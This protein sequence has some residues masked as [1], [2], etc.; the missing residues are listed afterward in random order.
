MDAWGTKDL[1]FIRSFQRVWPKEWCNNISQRSRLPRMVKMTAANSPIYPSE[2]DYERKRFLVGAWRMSWLF[3]NF[4]I[5]YIKWTATCLYHGLFLYLYKYF[6]CSK[7]SRAF[8]ERI[9]VGFHTHLSLYGLRRQNR[10]RENLRKGSE[11]DWTGEFENER[12][13]M[14]NY[15]YSNV[16]FKVGSSW[17]HCNVSEY[18]S[19]YLVHSSIC[20]SYISC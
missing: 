3:Y 9:K 18:H 2:T 7:C 15:S 4:T 19:V 6:E 10:W 5:R 12:N 17:F 16:T 1:V 20:W 11:F 13:Y 8:F 14:C